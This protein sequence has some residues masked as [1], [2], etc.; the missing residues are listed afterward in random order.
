MTLL[1]RLSGTEHLPRYA[2]ALTAIIAGALLFISASKI[3][4]LLLSFANIAFYFSYAMPVVGAVYLKQKGLWR[5]GPFS[6]GRWSTPITC[7][8]AIWLIFECVNIAWPR[9]ANPQWYLNWGV[10][11]MIGVLGLLGLFVSNYVFRSS[12]S[13]LQAE[14]K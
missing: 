4:T 1:A 14:A 2:I 6:L 13:S 8:A 3:Y 7:L 5:A 11:I 10:L 9:P 12:V